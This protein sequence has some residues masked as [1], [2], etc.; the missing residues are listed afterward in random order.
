MR[1]IIASLLLLVCLDIHGQILQAG[2]QQWSGNLSFGAGSPPVSGGGGGGGGGDNIA[3]RSEAHSAPTSGNGATLTEPASA[4]QNDVFISLAVCDTASSS[5]GIPSGWTSIYSGATATYRYNLCWIRRGASAPS[6]VWTMST[7]AYREVYILAYSGVTTS[8]NP[9]ETSADG[10]TTA[11]D[12][13]AADPP[14][15]TT[16][17]ANDWVIALGIDWSGSATAWTAPSG[18]TIRSSNAAG[19]DAFMADK[20]V[21]AAG[22]ENPATFTGRGAGNNIKWTATIALKSS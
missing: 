4:A 12:S 17:T 2:N 18:Y 1:K 13:T 21:A 7:S 6:L 16:S 22:A 20:K 15:V 11:S 5:L 19:N 3:F 9:Y 8:G 14:S 10:G